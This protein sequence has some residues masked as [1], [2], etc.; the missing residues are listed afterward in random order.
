M[1][2]YLLLV[3][4]SFILISCSSSTKNNSYGKDDSSFQRSLERN[5]INDLDTELKK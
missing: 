2:K 5:A 3:L 1:R 4:T